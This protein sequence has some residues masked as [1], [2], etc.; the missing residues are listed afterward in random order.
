MKALPYL[1]GGCAALISTRG[2]WANLPHFRAWRAHTAEPK[3]RH[4][5]VKPCVSRRL[6]QPTCG[7]TEHVSCMLVQARGQRP[8]RSVTAG[9]LSPAAASAQ[10]SSHSTS[11]VPHVLHM[12]PTQPHI[13]TAGQCT[14][15]SPSQGQAAGA[16][17]PPQSA[18][19]DHSHKTPHLA[20]IR[21]PLVVRRGHRLKPR[22]IAPVRD[23]T[24]TPQHSALDGPPAW[25]AQRSATAAPVSTCPNK[26]SLAP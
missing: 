22:A 9:W 4:P 5:H 26:R 10:S 11:H 24:W 17:A 14:N 3:R 13:S 16:A 6:L 20:P 15:R 18:D 1:S 21:H 12:H 2:L 25:P 7:H 19:A 8:G 23:L